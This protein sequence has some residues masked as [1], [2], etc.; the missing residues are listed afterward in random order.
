M[1]RLLALLGAT[2]IQ[3]FDLIPYFYSSWVAEKMKMTKRYLLAAALL[4]LALA[5]GCAKG[6][7]RW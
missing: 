2:L 5:G 1:S 7:T 3:S 4:S 6:G